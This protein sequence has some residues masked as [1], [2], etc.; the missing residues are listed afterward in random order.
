MKELLR[1]ISNSARKLLKKEVPK[2]TVLFYS[3]AF[4]QYTPRPE[5]V[6]LKARDRS[7][8]KT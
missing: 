8:M 4:V 7:G 2:M 1:S 5:A 3:V 6:A